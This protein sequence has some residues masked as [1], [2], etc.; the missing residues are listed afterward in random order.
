MS[1]WLLVTVCAMS[2]AYCLIRMRNCA[3]EER[4]AVGGEAVMGFGMA[5]MAL[6]A[7]AVTPPEWG[8]AVYAVVFGAAAARALWSSR[9]SGHHLHHLHHLMGSLAMVYMAVAMSG[10][11][12]AHAGHGPAGVPLVTGALLVYYAAYVLRAGGRLIP[13]AASLPSDAPAVPAS[14]PP[15]AV[16]SMAPDTAASAAPAS[17][18]GRPADGGWGTRPELALACRLSMG[19]AMLAMLL[20]L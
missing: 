12:G 2:G 3:R 18:T 11:G 7:A 20:T 14:A 17:T 15:S 10:S 9:D 6:P 1:G 13:V 19:M 8:W 5:A 16:L 4:E